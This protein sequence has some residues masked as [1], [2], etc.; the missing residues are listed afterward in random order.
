MDVGWET[1]V[2]L[3]KCP[4]LLSAQRLLHQFVLQNLTKSATWVR[5]LES[6]SKEVLKQT[7]TNIALI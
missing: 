3:L 5:K 2:N 4:V 1:S 6:S 7:Y